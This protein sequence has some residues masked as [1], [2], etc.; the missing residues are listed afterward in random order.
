MSGLRGAISD[1]LAFHEAMAEVY[2]EGADCDGRPGLTRRLQRQKWIHSEVR[3][4][5]EAI[6]AND[7]EAAV[8]ALNDII[9]LCTGTGIMWV[10]SERMAACWDEVQRSN[11]DKRL[12]DGT[13][14]VRPSDGKVQKPPGWVGPKIAEIWRCMREC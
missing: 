8:D 2:P 6:A 7:V 11:M 12:P 13:V 9:Y 4:F 5:D 1:V 14:L 10:G 3:E